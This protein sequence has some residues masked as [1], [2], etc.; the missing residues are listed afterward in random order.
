M[1]LPRPVGASEWR[2]PPPEKFCTVRS[3]PLTET[4][5]A[6]RDGALLVCPRHA[7]QLA[8]L[9]WHEVLLQVERLAE[10]R[11][12]VPALLQQAALEGLHLLIETLLHLV[13][14]LDPVQTGEEVGRRHSTHVVRSDRLLVLHVRS[15][16]LSGLGR[17]KHSMGVNER[18][19]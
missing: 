1:V 10:R 5:S 6:S 4:P 7:A 8:R 19:F 12:Q 14:V 16:R 11:L 3:Y 9:W 15:A 13:V 2:Q 18:T 17:E